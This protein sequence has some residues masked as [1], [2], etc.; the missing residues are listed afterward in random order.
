MQLGVSTRK[1]RQ[2][3]N[4]RHGRHGGGTEMFGKATHHAWETAIVRTTKQ[5]GHEHCKIRRESGEGRT[6]VRRACDKKGAGGALFIILLS[7]A[8]SI[9]SAD[10]SDVSS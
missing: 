6:T 1:K 7:T 9:I 2:D 4:Q 10:T 5:M 8:I 3:N